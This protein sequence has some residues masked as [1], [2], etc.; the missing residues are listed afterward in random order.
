MVWLK[1]YIQQSPHLQRKR[2][3]DT[4]K[5]CCPQITQVTSK[6]H[7]LKNNTHMLP[8]EMI[9]KHL[10]KLGCVSYELPAKNLK[11]EIQRALQK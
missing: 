1:L 2:F 5:I 8:A 4:T 7:I 10:Q 3:Q 9:K 11:N 6:Y